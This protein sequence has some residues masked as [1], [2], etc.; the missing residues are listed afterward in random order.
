MIYFMPSFYQ[1]VFP[2]RKSEFA[3]LNALLV[4]FGGTI[5][6]MMGGIISDRYKEKNPW[7]NTIIPVFS[8][9]VGVPLMAGCCLFAGVPFRVSL[10][11]LFVKYLLTETYKPPTITMM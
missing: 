6:N 3:L 7:I 9:L 11:F 8:G 5:S 1:K 10:A 4:S 2:T